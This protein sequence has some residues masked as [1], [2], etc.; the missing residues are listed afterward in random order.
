MTRSVQAVD[1]DK[2]TGR[3]QTLASPNF[4]VV[5]EHGVQYK[6]DLQYGQ[7]T[8]FYADQRESRALIQ[9]LARDR[10]VLDLCCYT[11]GFALASA[12]GGASQVTGKMPSQ[13]SSL[14]HSALFNNN[15]T[16]DIDLCSG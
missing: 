15:L 14:I 2:T 3:S 11:G 8:G 16:F 12:S 13:S 7:K 10:S 4:V 6:V 9:A 1:T 5:E